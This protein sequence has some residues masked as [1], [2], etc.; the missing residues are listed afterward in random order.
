MVQEQPSHINVLSNRHD[1]TRTPT[2]K[3]AWTSL[4][5]S[6]GLTMAQ[7]FKE[8]AELVDV[9]AGLDEH[10]DQNSWQDYYSESYL[11]H[12]RMQPR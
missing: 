11:L 3:D 2:S 9:D 4:D 5:A 8:V 1:F 7:T 12:I 6:S 10:I